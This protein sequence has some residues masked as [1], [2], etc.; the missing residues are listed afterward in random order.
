[1]NQ[2][3]KTV[4][5]L[6]AAASLS[7]CQKDDGNTGQV[8]QNPPPHAE[9]GFEEAVPVRPDYVNANLIYYGNGGDSE[10]PDEWLLNLYTDMEV[11]GGYPVGPGQ[12]LCI[13]FY[14]PANMAQEPSLNYLKGKYSMPPSSGL[15][16]YTYIQGEILDIDTPAGTISMPAGSF[17]GDIPAGE[18]EFDADLIREGDFTITDNG[19]G[20]WTIDGIL[21]GRQYT[22]RYFTYTGTF[23]PVDNSDQGGGQEIPN[24]NLTGDIGLNE[25]SLVNAR[26]LDKGDFFFTGAGNYRLFLL[27]LA[28][29][30]V[31]ISEDYPSGTGRLLHL[32]LL[33]PADA[34]PEDGIPAGEYTMANRISGGTFM[35]IEN[36]VPFRVVEGCANVF[37]YNTGTWYQ[38]L[39]DGVWTNY[40]RISGGT[41]TVE[42]DGD[43]H[44]LTIDLADCSDPAYKVSGVWTTDGPIGL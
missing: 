11:E 5:M 42:R 1:M 14:A 30:G 2:N 27:Y 33:V 9:G 19:D 21:V 16:E 34:D 25:Y 18:I 10:I 41:V 6:L 29:A 23:E 36:I 44:T 3:L 13:S 26:L 37:Q 32:E 7:A 43:A 28:E 22:K 35:P 4:L 39:T 12:Y 38:E 24:S 40:G 15:A 31:D 17:Y 20:T 8:P